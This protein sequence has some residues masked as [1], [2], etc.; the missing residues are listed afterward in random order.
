LDH[1]AKSD[2]CLAWGGQTIPFLEWLDVKSGGEEETNGIGDKLPIRVWVAAEERHLCTF[3]N[4]VEK[5]FGG[6]RSQV[7]AV[8]NSIVCLKDSWHWLVVDR[9]ELIYN[10]YDAHAGMPTLNCGVIWHLEGII[11]TGIE[12]C[13]AGFLMLCID[14]K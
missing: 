14:K 8:E 6:V 5:D 11:D 4:L 13:E 12:S 9:A 3:L 10:I 1:G 7:G 2:P